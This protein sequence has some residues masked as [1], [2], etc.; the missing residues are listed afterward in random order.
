MNYPK[1]LI[2]LILVLGIISVGYFAC[3]EKQ[4]KKILS[5]EENIVKLKESHTPIRFKIVDKTDE[6]IALVM[7][8]YNADNKEINK[9]ETEL[10]GQELSFDFYVVK[11]K[12]KYV[13]FPSK[14][15]SNTIAASKGKPLYS[16]YN[17]D[18]Y[19]EIYFAK[20]IDKDLYNGLKE[21]Y[22]KLINDQIDS[23][24]NSFGNMVHD[25]KDFKAFTPETVYSIVTHSKG[26]IEIVE[27]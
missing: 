4:E 13:A 3:I 7:K 14:L 11:V 18:G 12:D 25:I 15:F 1:L 9:L 24:E 27:E 21:V 23:L 19:P 17:N 20:N 16:W 5:L 26:G 2:A 10:E 8:F 6:T 22:Q